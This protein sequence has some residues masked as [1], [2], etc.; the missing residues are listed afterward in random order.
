MYL[1]VCI[2]FLMALMSSIGEAVNET[3]VD[4][5]NDKGTAVNE[6]KEI[7]TTVELQAAKVEIHDAGFLH[8]NAL[9]ALHISCASNLMH[10]D[11][12]AKLAKEIT[13]FPSE[14]AA[15]TASA[16][17]Q[18]EMFQWEAVA[19]SASAVQ[20][21]EI[22]PEQQAEGAADLAEIKAGR[23]RLA[24][25]QAQLH[26]DMNAAALITKADA[27]F[28]QIQAARAAI[29]PPRQRLAKAAETQAAWDAKLATHQVKLDPTRPTLAE[30]QAK[31]QAAK[32][33]KLAEV[34]A[35]WGAKHA[36]VAKEAKL[37]AAKEA[38]AAWR[39]AEI[40][41]EETQLAVKRAEIQA[42]REAKQAEAKALQAT[43]EAQAQRT[44]EEVQAAFDKAQAEA[45]ALLPTLNTL[46]S[47]S[48]L[49][50][51]SAVDAHKKLAETKESRTAKLAEY[52]AAF[53]KIFAELRDLL[54]QENDVTK[55]QLK[56][57]ME[58]IKVRQTTDM[59]AQ[60]QAHTEKPSDSD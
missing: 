14:A 60:P 34:N 28:T 43:H 5:H 17:Q 55:H 12:N 35:A 36:Q 37:R 46:G 42:T 4:L 47:A 32:T 18:Q 13:G 49:P 50:R 39:L 7:Q 15:T 6:T 38:D 44:Q 41:K 54:I 58:E 22:S 57:Q 24:D 23:H 21:Q 3:K 56:L 27:A 59:P 31:R 2:I 48:P 16:V 30:T 1:P 53:D 33:D 8:P 9:K 19:T 26:E 20:Q 40:V 51:R 10:P 52:Q 25:Y 29:T 45:K 11:Q